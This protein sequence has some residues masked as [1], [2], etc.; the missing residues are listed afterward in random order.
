MTL[1]NQQHVLN[2]VLLRTKKSPSSHLRLCHL[3]C[4]ITN[5]DQNLEVLYT[6]GIKSSH[7][8]LWDPLV[9]SSPGLALPLIIQLANDPLPAG[10][11]EFSHSNLAFVKPLM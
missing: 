5:S 11:N 1:S 2:L 6:T 3:P 10:A 7:F 4:H 9:L 8:Q